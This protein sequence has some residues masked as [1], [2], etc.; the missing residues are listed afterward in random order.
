VS[1]MLTPRTL[2]AHAAPSDWTPR[3]GDVTR[4]RRTLR[5]QDRRK[6]RE[7]LRRDVLALVA[8]D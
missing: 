2:R 1:V 3:T 4:V 5:R 6:L 8:T 7:T